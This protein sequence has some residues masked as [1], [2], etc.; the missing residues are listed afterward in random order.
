MATF[1]SFD[2]VLLSLSR[3]FHRDRRPS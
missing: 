3:T 1:R 2:G